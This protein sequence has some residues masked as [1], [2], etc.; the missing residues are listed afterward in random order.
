MHKLNSLPNYYHLVASQEVETTK[1]IAAALE[2]TDGSFVDFPN[3][4]IPDDVASQ[5]PPTEQGM[6]AAK[7]FLFRKLKQ[8]DQAVM[9]EFS[10]RLGSIFALIGG[11][12]LDPL[13]RLERFFLG[14]KSPAASG[15]EDTKQ[16]GFE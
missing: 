12:D 16:G 1:A 6:G 5:F 15:V 7:A 2:S 10:I 8:R 4:Y 13:C 11:F 3:Y 9:L 14:E